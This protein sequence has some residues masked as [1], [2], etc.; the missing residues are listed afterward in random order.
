MNRACRPQS[1]PFKPNK[2]VNWH[3]FSSFTEHYI[4]L[5][6]NN[7]DCVISASY[8]AQCSRVDI[9]FAQHIVLP[10]SCIHIRSRDTPWGIYPSHGVYYHFEYLCRATRKM[11]INKMWSSAPFMK[12]WISKF[13]SPNQRLLSSWMTPTRSR[14]FTC[15]KSV[16]HNGPNLDIMTRNKPPITMQFGMKINLDP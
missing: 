8:P 7:T 6:W 2:T 14:A 12:L 9:Y 4:I 11:T 10:G 13:P 5:L 1:L 3:S 16:T 15:W